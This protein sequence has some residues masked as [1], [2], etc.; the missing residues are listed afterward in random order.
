[1]LSGLLVVATAAGC[2]SSTAHSSW[3]TPTAAPT[4]QRAICAALDTDFDEGANVIPSHNP[5]PAAI[6][7]P[8]FGPPAA[9][10]TVEDMA[11]YVMFI[12]TRPASTAKIDAF[13]TQLQAH[14]FHGSPSPDPY[15]GDYSQ[16][17]PAGINLSTNGGP[18]G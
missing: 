4:Q 5:V 7:P 14:G 3:P 18:T 9:E 11:W 10:C 2:T 12:W 16:T 1:L 6:P 13:I 17:P 8:D 15:T